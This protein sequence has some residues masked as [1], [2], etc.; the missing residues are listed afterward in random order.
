MN[1]ENNK[2]KKIKLECQDSI[3]QCL[4]YQR[5]ILAIS[6]NASSFLFKIGFYD[7]DDSFKFNFAIEF[8]HEQMYEQWKL[9]KTKCNTLFLIGY[10]NEYNGHLD[11]KENKKLGIFLLNIEKKTIDK[12]SVFNYNNFVEDKKDDK[13]FIEN[14]EAIF[15]YD[16]KTNTSKEKQIEKIVDCKYLEIHKLF[17][18]DEY[19][20]FITLQ[21]YVKWT[22][23]ISKTVII[24]KNLNIINKI[25]TEP[26]E[27]CFADFNCFGFYNFIKGFI[28]ISEDTYYLSYEESTN[29][30]FSKIHLKGNE[31]LFN[32]DDKDK[33]MDLFDE[34]TIKLN[35]KVGNFISLF[36]LNEE[37]FVI[38]F[39][40][41]TFYIF[42]SKNLEL[43]T[44]LEAEIPSDNFDE[45]N[46]F[47]PKHKL[48]SFELKEIY[49]EIFY[50]FGKNELLYITNK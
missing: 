2:M 4:H 10:M 44:K 18:V 25:E 49:Y 29:C 6:Y 26:Y 34:V 24:D 13:L 5:Y 19:L 32:D 21:E 22:F 1:K 40:P 35:E 50:S 20:L 41:N 31:N 16:F 12:K 45:Q 47:E 37:K 43:I 23:G 33:F 39:K 9:Y 14:H 28:P 38:N 36:S 15:S 17:L 42:N 11:K 8:D 3:I 27:F 30:N 7:I 46:R 48:F